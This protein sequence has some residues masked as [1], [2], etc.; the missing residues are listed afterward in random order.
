MKFFSASE[1]RS[2]PS[3]PLAGG[4]ALCVLAAPA[5]A[6]DQPGLATDS[7]NEIVVTGSYLQS[8]IAQPAPVDRID[9]DDLA[10]A[11]RGSIGEVLNLTPAFAANAVFIDSQANGQ[12]GAAT[13]NLRG[14]GTRGTL[15]LLNGRRVVDNAEPDR[16]LTLGVDINSMMP[17]I[18]IERVDVLKDGASAL[19][20]SDAV[21]G[22]LNFIA[23]SRFE[24]FEADGGYT[25]IDGVNSEEYNLGAIAGVRF[26]S[27]HIVVAADYLRRDAFDYRRYPEVEAYLVANNYGN[28]T[29]TTFGNPGS[30]R[31]IPGE[32][33]NATVPAGANNRLVRDPLCGSAQLGGVGTAGIPRFL[34][35]PGNNQQVCSSDQLLARDAIAASERV[36]AYAG[37]SH[38]FSDALTIGAEVGFSWNHLYRAG[39]YA[40]P[41]LSEEP[42]VPA[43]N[44]GNPFGGAVQFRG[45][46][47]GAPSNSPLITDIDSKTWRAV[48][49]ASGRLPFLDGWDWD[50]SLTWGSNASRSGK[51]DTHLQR[52]RDALRGLGGPGCNPAMGTPGVGGCQYFNP[53]ANSYL[54]AAGSPQANSQQLIDY[55]TP[56]A[57]NIAD[58][59]LFF[60]RLLVR[61]E[62]FQLP[63]GPVRAAIGYEHRYQSLR[64]TYD[65]FT[66]R[67]EFAFVARQIPFF[68][69]LRSN[70]VFTEVRAP[71]T[72]NLEVQ[73]ALRYES[74]A[75]YNTLDPKIGLIFQPVPELTL[76]A[77]YGTS[78]RAAGL[79]QTF[80]SAISSQQI[81][82][83]G[84]GTFNPLLLTQ[85]NPNL[86]PETA[87]VLTAG[88]TIAPTRHLR[89]SVDYW[90]IDFRDLVVLESAQAVVNAWAASGGMVNAGR[91]TTLGGQISSVAIN[92][93]N[94][95]SLYTDGIDASVAFDFEPGFGGRVDIGTQW[96]WTITYDY[97]QG[98]GLPISRGVGRTNDTSA[99][100]TGFA[101]PE[102]RGNIT[103]VYAID[104][105]RFRVAVQ[106]TSGLLNSL[107]PDSDARQDRSS[108]TRLDLGYSYGFKLAGADLTLRAGVNNVADERPP[109]LAL[110]AFVP[111]AAGVYD[112]RGRTFHAGLTVGF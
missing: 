92:F 18:M 9:R 98:P 104:G 31:L 54:A 2:P 13:V 8:T 62:L 96:T 44:P 111:L 20:G 95:S 77:T 48:G 14:I 56:V 49:F 66:L 37:V 72:A 7:T 109:F 71:I 21:A 64:S 34:G 90:R 70:T 93:I 43:A 61:G 33:Y 67:G 63:A 15:V 32:T 19:Y 55:L 4:L 68:G 85:P 100:S 91:I 86:R 110:P 59:E 16:N 105:H 52:L 57:L 28:Q 53:F 103:L 58:T 11:P 45:R 22:V 108:D 23:R 87:D 40:F 65:D 5:F 112:P 51:R 10:A 6:Q 106:H 88:A 76:R 35:P 47:S 83:P 38:E 89:F 25:L 36:N 80:G 78:F 50:A 17:T 75:N 107:L 29:L 41:V 99:N 27:T 101:I 39:G 26:G 94:A 82:Q 84:F 60:G 42:L 3:I 1:D 81:T 74:Y 12:S 73:G 24:G 102:F 46:I 69:S 79:I 30:F 97:R